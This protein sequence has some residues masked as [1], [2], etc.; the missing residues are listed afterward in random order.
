MRFILLIIFVLFASCVW[1]RRPF[2]RPL[3]EDE[4][5]IIKT[6][7]VIE[8]VVA[9]NPLNNLTENEDD[10][11][12]DAINTFQYKEEE[13]NPSALVTTIRYVHLLHTYLGFYTCISM[14][15]NFSQ[16]IQVKKLGI[17]LLRLIL[18][19]KYKISYIEENVT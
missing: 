5:D 16:E 7:V 19:L 18:L 17:Y 12:S 14:V 10:Q 1:A 9:E 11:A 3:I 13:N 2:L 15:R 6:D 4:A 8:K